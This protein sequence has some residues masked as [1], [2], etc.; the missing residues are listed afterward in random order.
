[1]SNK[2]NVILIIFFGFMLA[3]FI[4][5]TNMVTGAVEKCIDDRLYRLTDNGYWI[6]YAHQ[7]SCKPV[8]IKEQGE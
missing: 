4:G 7:S 3:L 1:M 5:V 8:T 2:D 6:A